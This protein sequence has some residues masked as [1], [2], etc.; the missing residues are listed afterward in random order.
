MLKKTFLLTSL[1]VCTLSLGAK[2]TPAKLL[3]DNMVLQQKSNVCMWGSAE[4]NSTVKITTSWSKQK[5][6]TKCD[7]K[8]QWSVKIATPAASNAPQTVTFAD[9]KGKPL[10][11]SNVLIGEVWVASGQSNM[12]MGMS[13]YPDCPVEG[14]QEV[15]ATSG[16]YSGIRMFTVQKP[17]NSMT[18][19]DTVVGGTWRTSCPKNVREFSA[20]AYFFAIMLNKVLN[21]PIGIITSSWGGTRIESWLPRDRADKYTGASNR[22]NDPQPNFPNQPSALF[23]G[24]IN[25]ITRYNCAGFIWYQGEANLSATDY[26]SMLKDLSS[27][28]R[29]LWGLG[30]LPFYIVEIA[31]FDYSPWVPDLTDA[32]RLRA[33]QFKAAHEI[34]N[35][36]IV[37]TNDLVRPYEQ[38]QIHPAKKREVG[39]RLAYLAL[40]YNY[41][42]PELPCEGPSFKSMEINSDKAIITFNN[43]DLGFSTPTGPL[44]GFEIAGDDKVFHPANAQIIEHRRIQ[45][46]SPDVKT[47]VAVR[48]C[49]KDFL[50]GNVLDLHGFPLFPFRTDNW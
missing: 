48:Y 45:V 8:G 15:I 39:N 36:G 46:S 37:G 10:T 49:Y 40:H 38:H 34:V 22:Y 47:P 33:L 17:S 29:K 12:D 27:S 11:L 6:K 41:G 28:W 31:P 50:L 26:D 43:I 25:P 18:P 16:Q 23:N 32:G 9:G 1:L 24:M 7:S 44:T 2:V 3:T 20:T 30:D 5:A 4:P 21:I 19:Q 35:S 42:M 14:G 13:T